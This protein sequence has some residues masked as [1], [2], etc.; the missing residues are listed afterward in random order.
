MNRKIVFSSLAAVV[1]SVASLSAQ[2]RP[3][4]A[5]GIGIPL[6]GIVIGAPYYPAPYG[7]PGYYRG[8][9]FYGPAPYGYYGW[10]RGYRYGGWHDHDGHGFHGGPGRGPQHWGR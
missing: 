1:L 10:D 6:P 2:A 8:G 7:Y 9:P 4:V 3:S 5:I